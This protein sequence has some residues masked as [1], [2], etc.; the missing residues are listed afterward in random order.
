MVS[1]LLQLVGLACLAAF[2]WIVW[3][4]LVLAVVGVAL[5]A[6]PEVIERR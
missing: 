6:G 5:V 1:A 3:P 4:P 2:L